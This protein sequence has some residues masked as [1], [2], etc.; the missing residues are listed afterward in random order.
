M[1]RVTFFFFLMSLLALGGMAQENVSRA[2]S[3]GQG[4]MHVRGA[5]DAEQGDSLVVIQNIT[6][7]HNNTTHD[8]IIFRELLFEI[9]DTLSANQFLELA[10]QSRQNLL[11]TSLF[12]F[13]ELLADFDE[14]SNVLVHISF[15]E[16]W[17][18]WPFPILELGDR[19]LNAFLGNPRLSRLNYGLKVIQENFRG[20]KETLALLLRFGYQQNYSL[21]YI[22]PYINKAQTLGFNLDAGFNMSRELA[23]ATRNNRQLFYREPSGLIYKQFFVNPGLVYRPAIHSTHTLSLGFTRYEFAD[24]LLKLNPMFTHGKRTR[25]EYFVLSYYYKNDHR[26]IRAYPLEGYYM[27]VRLTRMGL[28]LIP[29]GNMDVNMLE[30]SGRK[31]WNLAPRWYAAG[32]FNSKL[33]T[34]SSI[35]Y[36]NQQGLG[37]KGDL[38]RGFENYVV[39]GQHFFVMKSNLKYTLVPQ[40]S[41]QIGII[42]NPRFSLIHYAIY[43]NLYADA[44]IVHDRLFND[45]NSLSNQW[46]GGTGIG[47]DFVTYY[48]RVFRVEWSFNSLG[49]SGLF[50]HLL[51]PI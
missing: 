4:A 28:G 38:V 48:D 25:V 42:N 51:A 21:N 49:E 27:D 5:P 11:N 16:R 17:Y 44:G 50:F 37:F 3:Q 8:N 26:D 41:T 6:L 35:A 30:I 24:T 34:G 36:F 47:L 22:K 40:R 9:G 23:Y 10:K 7:E 15:V 20:R 29:K 2:T 46:L 45:F 19:N 33:S 39:D 31:F 14:D 12:N 32:G 13:V 43:M 18:L 1:R